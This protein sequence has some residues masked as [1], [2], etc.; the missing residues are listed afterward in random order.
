MTITD[1][2][3]LAAAK[4]LKAYMDNADPAEAARIY[5]E[6]KSQFGFTDADFDQA[7]GGLIGASNPYGE[8]FQQTYTPGQEQKYV[9]DLR[10]SLD[11]H[12]DGP[13]GGTNVP[14]YK[15]QTLANY[16]PEQAVDLYNKMDPSLAND[17]A[18]LGMI[19]KGEGYWKDEGHFAPG[20]K[21]TTADNFKAGMKQ[22]TVDQETREKSWG[23]PRNL[24]KI[25]AVAVGGYALAPEMFGAKMAT[26]GGFTAA[27]I[28]ANAGASEAFVPM[29]SAFSEAEIAMNAGASAMSDL[30]ASELANAGAGAMTDGLTSA[31]NTALSN[32]SIDGSTANNVW[33]AGTSTTAETV[34]S[35]T[36]AASDAQSI[37]RAK[38]LAD[39]AA[40][41][42]SAAGG[43][44]TSTTDGLYNIVTNGIR[45]ATSYIS[46]ALNIKDTGLI[47]DLKDVLSIGGTAGA[48]IS[49]FDYLMKGLQGAANNEVALEKQRLDN[50]GR[51]D[52]ANI[53]ATNNLDI[54]KLKDQQTQ[55]A[56]KR[57]SSSVSGINYGLINSTP[58]P[59][60]RNDGS[61]VFSGN[62][63]IN[64]G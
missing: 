49:L 53:N 64:R 21:I 42:N 39:A 16:T 52:V 50:Q 46:E 55:D 3:V 18:M 38:E 33:N 28:L 35:A 10:N 9:D 31:Q 6:K 41:I 60:T 20:Q 30:G 14:G 51:I 57:Y 15:P 40:G 8:F 29:A 62:G 48:G 22:W 25:A 63:L 7:S 45:N 13:E 59:L 36:N 17:P 47:K 26:N 12:E 27:E 4:Q 1:P 54:L 2:A 11:R 61:R 5:A 44:L 58:K 34:G 56:N 43:A 32:V 37:F 23:S 24:A 19:L